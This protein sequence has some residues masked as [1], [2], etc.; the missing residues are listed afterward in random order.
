MGRAQDAARPHP[1]TQGADAGACVYAEASDVFDVG[2]SRRPGPCNL[3]PRGLRSRNLRLQNLRLRSLRSILLFELGLEVLAVKTC[4][5]AQRNVLGAF[6]SASAGIGTVAEA[7]FVHLAYHCTGAASTFYLTLGQQ[8]KLAD[9][10]GYKEHSRAVF[11]GSDTCAAADASS[12]IHSHI[13]HLFGDGYGVGI[14]GATGVEGYVT[15]GL[16]NLVK[17][18]AADHEIADYGESGRAP[19]L[20]GDGV[21]IVEFA[22]VQLACGDT[23]YG[24]VGVAVNVQRAHTADAF[25][26][27]V[28]EYYGFFTGFDKLLIEHVK[29]LEEAAAGGDV[30]EVVVLELPFGSGAALAPNA[31]VYAYSLFHNCVLCDWG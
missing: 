1:A 18:I 16:L 13:G 2:S 4:D 19:R 12:A 15:A 17:G 26:A 6:G 3:R 8:C 25:A 10:G 7:E 14:G 22:H 21:T 23:L 30:V 9:L 20:D 27:V 31:Q 11:A 24:A 5:I 29:H 28:V